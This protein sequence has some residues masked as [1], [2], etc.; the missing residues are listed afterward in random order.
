MKDF[1]RSLFGLKFKDLLF[2]VFLII[3][4]IILL[5]IAYHINLYEDETYTLNTTSRNMAGVVRQSYYFEGQPPVY[6]IL[7]ALWRHLYPG[8]FFIKLFSIIIIGLSAFFLYKIVQLFSDVIQ[9]KWMVVIFLLN[10]FTIWAA[11]EIRTYSLLILLA[12]VLIYFFYRFYFESKNKFLYWFLLTAIIGIYTQYFFTLLVTALGGALLIFKGW[13]TFLRF[14]LYLIP[15]VLVFLPNLFFIQ[16]QIQMHEIHDE[17]S[18]ILNT[19]FSVIHTPLNQIIPIDGYHFNLWLNRG[20]RIVFIVLIFFSI[21]KAYKK[22]YINKSKF[23]DFFNINILAICF[24]IILFWLA[25][26]LTDIIY[27]DKYMSVC[28]PLFILILSLFSGFGTRKGSIIYG[29]FSIYFI[30][31]SIATYQHPVKTFDFKSIAKYIEKIER[32]GEPILFYRSAISLPFK[33]YYAGQNPYIPL[34]HEVNYAGSWV[35]NIKDT[36]EL[37]QSINDI[38][39][40]S[41]SYLLISD[42]TLFESTINMHRKIITD[43]LSSHYNVTLDTLYIGWSQNRPLRI[44]RLEKKN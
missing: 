11:L 34:P 29:I 33:Y 37:K 43:Y 38:K 7:L 16:D 12:T 27:M 19:L 31:L 30:I 40:S 44:R 8:I 35:V 1:N 4:G 6:F 28:F 22:G 20:I 5:Y 41:P 14:C 39:T 24:L 26:S 13:K 23:I 25:V 32:P 9:S 21:G 2:A 18:F 42:L 3:Y 15:V 36:V 10:P 17:D